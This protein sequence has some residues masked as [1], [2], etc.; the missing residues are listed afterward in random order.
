MLVSKFYQPD[1]GVGI[2]FTENVF[3]VSFDGSFADEKGFGYLF[4]VVFFFYQP[5]D[6]GFP[7]GKMCF[8]VL[9]FSCAAE[10]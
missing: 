5:D 1:N 9:F 8:Y 6:L 4:I 10:F 7:V 2:C 3:A